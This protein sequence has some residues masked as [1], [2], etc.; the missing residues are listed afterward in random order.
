MFKHDEV[1]VP[2]LST[3]NIN[4]KDSIRRSEKTLSVYYYCF[5]KTQ[6]GWSYGVEKNVGDEV[7]NYIAGRIHT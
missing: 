7:A 5:A 6:N 1:S 4:R 3:K 2:E